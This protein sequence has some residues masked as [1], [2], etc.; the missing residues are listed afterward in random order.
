M[1]LEKNGYRPRIIDKRIA[2][3]LKLFGAVSI[4]GPKWCGKTWTSLKHANSVVYIMDPAGNY[5]NRE[6]AKINPSLIL[7]GKAPLAIDE[8]QEVPGIWDAVRFD[9]DQTSTVGKYI[10]T[11]SVTPPRKSY[12]HSGAGRFAFVR[13]RPMTLFESGDSYGMISFESLF[14]DNCID[15]FSIDTDLVTLIDITVRGGWPETIRLPMEK[16]GLVSEAYINAIIKNELLRE[17]FSKRNTAK[18]T[19]LLRALARSNAAPVSNTTLSLDMDGNTRQEQNASEISVSRT[20]VAEYLNDLKRLFIIEEIPGWNPGIRSKTRIRMAP[21]RIFSDPSLAIATLGL[22]RERLLSDLNTYG[23]MFENL[24]LRDIAVYAENCGGAVCHYRDNA[25]LEADAIVEMPDGTWGAFE[26][27]LGEHQVD[28]AALSLLR[29]KEKMTLNGAPPPVCLVVITGG[30]F[31]R[32]RKDGV[33]VVP[34]T[35]LQP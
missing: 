16:T 23:F 21:K 7:D 11:G 3:Y 34:I 22:N 30:G 26:I 9:V 29:L 12:T 8:W 2:E 27:K 13:M 20:T 32:Q 17:D 4:E 18:L 10:L 6:K 35:A 33:C 1:T 14:R 28:A 24:C 31:G 25:G 5:S 19:K 15:A